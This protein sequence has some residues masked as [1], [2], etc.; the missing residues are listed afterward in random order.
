MR[1]QL[2]ERLGRIDG[3]IIAEGAFAPGPALWVGKREIAHFDDEHTLDVRLTRN[4]ISTRRSTLRVDNRVVLR[5]GTSDWLEV[6]IESPVDVEFAISL[7]VEAVASN[8]E[9]AQPG[10]PPT[11]AELERRRRFH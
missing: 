4:V 2:L 11:G 9:T 7:V 6:K 5:P 1:D 3:A 10:L 8:L